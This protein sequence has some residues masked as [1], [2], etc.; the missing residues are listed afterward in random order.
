MTKP[1]TSARASTPALASGA[2]AASSARVK[3]DGNALVLGSRRVPLFSGALHYFQHEPSAWRPALEALSRMGLGIVETYIPWGIHER[4]DG[5]FDFGA[6][7]PRKNLS[8]FLDLA[9]SLGFLVIARPGP[10]INAELTYFGLPARIV[11][12]GAC[13]ARSSRG[14]PV[15]FIAPPRMFPVPSYASERFLSETDRWFAEVAKVIAPRLWPDGPVVMLQVDNEAAFYFRDGPYDQDY[16]PDALTKYRGFLRERYATLGALD[17]AYAATHETWEQVSAPR[18]FEATTRG[19]L[20]RQLD[21]MA[22]HEALICGALA[23]M[24]QS[25][26]AHGLHGVPISHNL[27]PG[28]AGLPAQLAR[29]DRD[30]DVVG[31]DYYHRRDELRIVRDRTLRLV[32]SARMAYAPEMGIGAPPWF[33]PRDDD[34][35]LQTALC[36]LAYGVRGMNLYMAVDRDRWYGAPIDHE[37]HARAQAEPLTRLFATLARVG[38]HELTRKVEVAIS[39]PKEYAQ[40]SRASHLLGALSPTFLDLL[41]TGASAASLRDPLGFSASIQTEWSVLTQRFARALERAGVPYVLVESDAQLDRHTALRLVI[42]PSYDFADVE[43][44]QRTAALAERGVHVLYGPALPQL[45]GRLRPHTFAEPLGASRIDDYA[46]T[47]ADYVIG[48]LIAKHALAR[49][50][51]CLAPGVEAV[52]HEDASGPRVVFVVNTTEAT[53]AAELALE[54]PI[55]LLDALNDERYEGESAITI[56]IGAHSVRMFVCQP[57][58]GGPTPGDR[59]SR[60][61]SARRSAAPC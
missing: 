61:P 35:S 27:P 28:E 15:P 1:R 36:A 4:H 8:A 16:H 54:T 51:S 34:D 3:L 37:G 46:Q 29:I 38:F 17:A 23:R 33:A 39:L 11:F 57:V 44:W 48:E 5:N 22:F 20:L 45:D 26:H 49:P 13:Q 40:L 52:V 7:D 56:P 43:R 2:P 53:C 31:L 41:G 32:G 6:D 21:W 19:A 14:N 9:Q 47:N 58:H 59:R 25:L 12:D 18:S 30:L 55:A 50:F 60:A 10:H 42:A 24:R